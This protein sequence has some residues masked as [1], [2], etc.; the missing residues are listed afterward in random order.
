MPKGGKHAVNPVL[1]EDQPI[2]HNRPAKIALQKY[3]VLSP[4]YEALSSPFTVNDIYSRAASLG[5]RSNKSR[6]QKK[7]PNEWSTRSG[8]KKRHK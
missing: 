4:D 5:I 1:V 7:N 3:D 8:N 2:P 6:N